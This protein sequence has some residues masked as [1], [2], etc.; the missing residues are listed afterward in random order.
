MRFLLTLFLALHFISIPVMAQELTKLS[1]DDPKALGLVIMED[2]AIKTEGKSSIKITT[3]W[4]TV[5]CLGE[6][7]EIDASGAKLV[8]RAKV[9]TEI[10]GEAFLEMWVTVNGQKYFS[11]GLDDAVKGRSDWKEIKTFFMFEKGQKPEK[12]T[13]NLSVNGT[14]AVWIDDAVISKE[15][16]K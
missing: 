9:R 15:Q 1:L 16:L 13:L 4:P 5:I 2:T 10:E 11:R 6:T 14:G 12:I 3:N 8:Y 7:S